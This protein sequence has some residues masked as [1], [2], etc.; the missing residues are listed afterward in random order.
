MS[1]L[2]HSDG[3][4]ELE[5]PGLEHVRGSR[6]PENSQPSAVGPIRSNCSPR[7]I[8]TER[9]SC[10]SCRKKVCEQRSQALRSARGNRKQLS[11]ASRES[12]QSSCWVGKPFSSSRQGQS[13]QFR[14]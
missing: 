7:K 9:N 3:A 5:K 4:R 13:R 8:P 10:R 11:K 12:A 2:S 1:R 6:C 14:S